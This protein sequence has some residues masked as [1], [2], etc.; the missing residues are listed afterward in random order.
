MHMQ[1]SGAISSPGKKDILKIY[2]SA[3]PKLI[4]NNEAV[5]IPA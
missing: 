5:A 4:S 2:T 1:P 3:L